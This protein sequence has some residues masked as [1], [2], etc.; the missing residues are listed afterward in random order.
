[1]LCIYY[2]YYYITYNFILNSSLDFKRY[3]IIVQFLILNR[4]QNYIGT[5]AK[6]A[7]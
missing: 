3:F 7:V 6:F 5:F 1:M 2:Y 4:I